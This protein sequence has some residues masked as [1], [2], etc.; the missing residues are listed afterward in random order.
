MSTCRYHSEKVESDVLSNK[1]GEPVPNGSISNHLVSRN[2]SPDVH[3][4]KTATS[5]QRRTGRSEKFGTKG[6]RALRAGGL[7]GRFRHPR[8]RYLA[9]A[10]GWR[11]I[12]PALMQ[13]SNHQCGSKYSRT[14]RLEGWTRRQKGKERGRKV[15]PSVYGVAGVAL[16]L[17]LIPSKSFARK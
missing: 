15:R 14:V 8:I 17:L 10:C 13:V 16:T 1:V 6:K 12:P 3:V 7:E 2:L 11:N 4:Y 9:R 5:G